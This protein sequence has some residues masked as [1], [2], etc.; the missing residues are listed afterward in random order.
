MSVD[1]AVVGGPYLDLV[2]EGLPRLP[3]PGEE[4]VGAG[5]HA[6]PGGSAIQAIGMARLGMSVALVAP[7]GTDA[8]GR[9]IGE[10]L[11]R[12]GVRWIGPEVPRTPTT[13]ILSSAGGTAMATALGDGE[14]SPGEVAGAD[15]S[16]VVLSLGRAGLRPPGIPACFVTGSIEIEAGTRVPEG[17]AAEGDLLVMNARE[18]Q[19]MTGTADLEASARTLARGGATAVITTGDEGAIGARAGELVRARAP[20]VQALDATGAGDL[21]VAALVWATSVG[22]TL[23]ASLEWAC[24]SAG[25][26]VTAPTALEGARHL[27][28]LI[29]EG[30]RRGLTPP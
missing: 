2:F 27:D 22:L 5:F 24:L 29:A 18:A 8:G 16:R 14:P 15:P 4:V 12:E 26:S 11:E 25:L 3:G 23:R 9:L 10:A 6:V 19:A 17:A 13:A 7:R 1:A 30:R 21:F 28:E 20:V